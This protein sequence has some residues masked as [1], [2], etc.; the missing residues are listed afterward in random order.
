MGRIPMLSI[1]LKARTAVALLA[2]AALVTPVSAGPISDMLARHRQARQTKLPPMS[3]PFD[4]RPVKDLS[5][6]TASLSERFK[7]RFSLKRGGAT[8]GTSQGVVRTSR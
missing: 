2:I 4:M 6:K 8:D 1:R 5:V 7:K 3:K